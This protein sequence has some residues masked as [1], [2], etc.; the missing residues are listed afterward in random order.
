M[1]TIPIRQLYV[2]RTEPA[3]SGKFNIRKIT[4]LLDGKDMLEELHRHDFFYILALE[5]GAGFHDIDFNPYT[6]SDHS[7]FFMRPGQV[8]KIGLKE[9]SKGYLISFRDEFYFPQD[10]TSG[11]LLRKASHFNHYQ[12]PADSFQKLYG[13]LNDIFLEHSDKKERYQEAIKANLELFFIGLLRQQD[14]RPAAH[15]N[16]YMQ[17]QLE[18]FLELLEIHVFSH[19]QVSEYAEMLNLST[20]QLNAIAKTTLGKTCLVLINEY[21]ILESKRYLLATS[22]QVNQIAHHLGYE[23]VSYFIRFF[24]KHTGS[25]PEEF[26]HNFR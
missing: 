1:E 25:S 2:T 8:H 6:I 26:R 21:L 18:K 13:V 5:K 24:K 14:N 22:G 16:L 11:Q 12:F 15:A 23:D 9:G 7:V 10:K 19:K 3:L 17:E 20:Y 4:E